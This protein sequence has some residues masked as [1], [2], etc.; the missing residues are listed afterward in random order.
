MIEPIALLVVDMLQFRHVPKLDMYSL[1][2]VETTNDMSFL[3][4]ETKYDEPFQVIG[5]ISTAI[6]VFLKPFD[7]RPRL[8]QKS[9]SLI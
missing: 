1:L 4:P 6:L 8:N 9:D 3:L 5:N 2:L 7:K